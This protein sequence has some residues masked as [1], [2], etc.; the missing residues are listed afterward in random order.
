MSTARAAEWI[1]FRGV[2]AGLILHLALSS[3][4]QATLDGRCLL[5]VE[6]GPRHAT[7]E[8]VSARRRLLQFPRR[9]A[10]DATQIPNKIAFCTLVQKLYA[11]P[12]CFIDLFLVIFAKR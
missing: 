2:M 8:T 10:P 9:H 12:P 6:G 3:T 7:H 5:K 11:C 4:R 1:R